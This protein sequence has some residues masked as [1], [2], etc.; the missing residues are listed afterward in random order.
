MQ[1]MPPKAGMRCIKTRCHMENEKIVD[2]QGIKKSFS[3]VPVLKGV[4]LALQRGEIVALMGENGAGKSTLVNI[5]MG[6]HQKDGGIIKINGQE[7][8]EYNINT[9]RKNGIAIIPQELALVPAVTVAENIF[10]SNRLK[11]KMGALSLKQMCI[12]AREIIDELGFDLDPSARV[13]SLP[14]SYRQLVSI[15]KVI[16]EEANVIIMDEPTSSLSSEEIKRLQSIIFKLKQRGV[17]VIYISHLLDEVFEV[18]DTII[19]LRDGYFIDSKPKSQTSQR[20]VISLMVGEELL[21]TQQA[22]RSE[23][24]SQ[25]GQENGEAIFSVENLHLSPERQPISFQLHEGEV[26]GITG[27]VGSGKTETLRAI[28]GVDKYKGFTVQ[29]DGKE[30]KFSNMREALAHGICVVPED[31]KLQGLVLVRSVRENISMCRT[32]RSKITKY[33]VIK[34]KDEQKD[35]K[36]MLEELAIKVAGLEQQV[37][38]LSG[39]NQ[40]KCVIAKELLAAP[41]ILMLD[42]PTRGIDVGAKTTIYNLIRKL[43]KNGLSVI[44]FTSDVSEIPIV[45]DRVLVLANSEI[46]GEI[47]GKE[48]T[49]PSILHFAAG[50]KK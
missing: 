27:L 18:A 42:E 20:E 49:V 34:R 21:H 7:F 8:T 46:V 45:C 48:V 5:L 47:E 41:R 9:A 1:R 30:Q 2:L 37:R 29:L 38:Y 11:G 35:V 39:G 3:G 19:V 14:I 50:G 32:Y 33:G 26:L 12:K 43:K 28:T 24:E 15:V 44:L 25:T 36:R 6:V 31:R 4:D 17:A 23:I 22:L 13:D 10:L 40:Q 16:A